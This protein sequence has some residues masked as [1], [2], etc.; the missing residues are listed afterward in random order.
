MSKISLVTYGSLINKNELLNNDIAI[1]DYK[2]IILNGFKREFSQE[3]SWRKSTSINRAVLNTKEDSN[4]FINALLI[5]I[6]IKDIEVLDKR[7]V[8]YN[9][10]KVDR[11]S[12]EFKYDLIEN[13]KQNDIFIY[14]GK[15]EKYNNLI[16]PN[17]DYMNICI[18]G[19]N[20]WGDVFYNDFIK[21]TFV[22]DEALEDFI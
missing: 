4:H 8:G 16:L 10:L 1:L 3:P 13:I 7:E 12:I 19:A 9:R 18:Q 20:S 14:T 6:Y 21:S 2:P 15:P 22:Q 17:L 5:D 11:N